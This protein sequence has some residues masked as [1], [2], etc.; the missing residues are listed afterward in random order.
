MGDKEFYVV[1]DDNLWKAYAF[2]ASRGTN[3]LRE[4]GYGLEELFR[5]CKAADL[6]WDGGMNDEGIKEVRDWE[7]RGRPVAGIVQSV[8]DG[9][10][11]SVGRGDYQNRLSSAAPKQLATGSDK[12]GGHKDIIPLFKD[13]PTTLTH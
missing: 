2:N 7:A 3:T 4:V 9:V 8:W 10:D 6:T 12:A 5:K 13:G 11:N 1:F